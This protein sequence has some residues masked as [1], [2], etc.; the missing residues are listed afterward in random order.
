[1]DSDV[2]TSEITPQNRKELYE[3]ISKMKPKESFDEKENIHPNIPAKHNDKEEKY[4]L[5]KILNSNFDEETANFLN[6][7]I[8]HF[9]INPF[10]RFDV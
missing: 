8:R 6:N 3:K 5:N 1:M 4:G 2:V 10:R 9:R 7:S